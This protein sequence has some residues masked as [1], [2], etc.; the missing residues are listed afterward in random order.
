MGEVHNKGAQLDQEYYVLG[1]P[2]GLQSEP[3]CR[4]G[5]IKEGSGTLN[6][7]FPATI[8][9][10]DHPSIFHEMS[11]DF[12]DSQNEFG[13]PREKVER[14]LKNNPRGLLHN[15]FD[16]G[17][18]Q[19]QFIRVKPQTENSKTSSS[20]VEQELKIP[21]A[22][23]PKEQTYY[24]NY[25]L[26]ASLSS[27]VQYELVTVR[28]VKFS[29]DVTKAFKQEIKEISWE[30]A[31]SYARANAPQNLSL[32]KVREENGGLTLVETARENPWIDGDEIGE[33]TR[34]VYNEVLPYIAEDKL[35]SQVMADW[36]KALK[37]TT[38]GSG[39]VQVD[40]RTTAIIRDIILKRFDDLRAEIVAVY[41]SLKVAYGPDSDIAFEDPSNLS[42][43]D[44][45]K[46]I[47]EAWHH[48]TA[49]EIRNRHL[50]IIFKADSLKRV[51]QSFKLGYELVRNHPGNFVLMGSMAHWK[52]TGR[53]LETGE[54]VLDMP[55]A[56]NGE[57]N[58][59]RL[60]DQESIILP[61]DWSAVLRALKTR[62]QK[63]RTHSPASQ[64]RRLSFGA[65]WVSLQV[66]NKLRSFDV[67]KSVASIEGVVS[68]I[69]GHLDFG[70][71][72]LEKLAR[73]VRKIVIVPE[74][75]IK[76]RAMAALPQQI[77]EAE[78]KLQLVSDR[79]AKEK[80][81]QA[82]A[83]LYRELNEVCSL[84]KAIAARQNTLPN[85]LYSEAESTIYLN[86]QALEIL[87]IKGVQNLIAHEL[88]H[89]DEHLRKKLGLVDEKAFK[90]VDE[91]QSG[92]LANDK[93]PISSHP[94][95]L[96]RSSKASEERRAEGLALYWLDPE[97]LKQ[98]PDLA[99]YFGARSLKFESQPY[100]VNHDKPYKWQETKQ[101]GRFI[102]KGPLIKNDPALQLIRDFYGNN[103]ER[104]MKY[105]MCL[106][107]G[108][109]NPDQWFLFDKDACT[110]L[111]P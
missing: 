106:N 24:Q 90:E 65:G 39:R 58:F 9:W 1:S 36:E 4:K 87:D 15:Y 74:Q 108:A 53:V 57:V 48:A 70:P 40:S 21:S 5:Q 85:G 73:N 34:T 102:R 98:F 8:V 12:Q 105:Y 93:I 64:K 6:T 103:L 44:I 97:R 79:L 2:E 71:E 111:N 19:V 45:F 82:R 22:W 11:S 16:K 94:D 91:Y 25:T 68:A 14:L 30:E 28:R 18:T 10:S 95:I 101:A 76:A 49:L 107:N 55:L 72:Y 96:A 110:P 41:E 80:N 38:Q 23:E 46:K 63:P 17:L 52:E 59:A 29:S 84:I 20:C 77:R 47:D 109:D 69:K 88:A 50:D 33:M 42:L 83:I 66:S 51:Y 43:E 86:A 78:K 37:G 75:E 13:Y 56:Q 62:L 32:V 99:L 67:S 35:R 104:S 54:L 7:G 31:L 61:R 89:A 81:P 92:F 60:K 100:V 27:R 26:Y 3:Q